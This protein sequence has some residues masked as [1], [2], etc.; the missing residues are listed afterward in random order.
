MPYI[1]QKIH[2]IILYYYL[3]PLYHNLYENYDKFIFVNSS[4]IGPFIPSYYKGKWTDIYL[5]SLKD[6]V[7]L[8]GST[9]NTC[10]NPLHLSHVQSY[11]FAMDKH[12]LQY[13]I[14]VEIFSTKI[15]MSIY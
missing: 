9:I 14:D 6:N 4:V 13:L 3:Y 8:F 15:L 12:T 5:N 2:L 11:I 7:K 10:G 1:L